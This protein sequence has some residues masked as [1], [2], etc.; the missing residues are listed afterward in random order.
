MELISNIYPK[1]VELWNSAYAVLGT[2]GIL[3]VI[4]AAL[5]IRGVGKT[6]SKIV[7]VIAGICI[8]LSFLHISFADCMNFFSQFFKF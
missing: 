2:G 5:I 8:I 6:I 7:S 1:A 3:A 4:A